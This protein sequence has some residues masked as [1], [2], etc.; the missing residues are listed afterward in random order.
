M[1]DRI[2]NIKTVNGFFVTAARGSGDRDLS[3]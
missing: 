1:L 2:G 3:L